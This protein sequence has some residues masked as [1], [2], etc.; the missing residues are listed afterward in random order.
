MATERT[1]PAWPIPFA[2]ALLLWPALWNGYPI[3]FADTGTYL[4]QAIHRYIGWDRPPFYS[5]AI[6]CLHGTVTTWP[7]V[8]AQA[9]ITAWVLR[10][11]IA[12]AWPGLDERWLPV[13]VLPLA[14]GT[15][16]PFLVSELTPDVFTPLLVLGWVT[17]GGAGP[18]TAGGHRWLPIL[19]AF[20]I[21]AQQSSLL[22]TL[23]LLPVLIGLHPKGWRAIMLPPAFAIAA[24]VA[25]NLAGH[26]RAAI[27]PFGQVFLLA[28]VIYDGPGLAVLRR[29]CPEAGWRLCPYRDR[30]PP[31]SDDFLWQADSPIVLAGGHK[32]IA[33]E[34]NA[35]IAAAIL[36]APGQEA[37]AT[38]ANAAEQITRF[39]SG[40]GLESW[41][42]QVTPWIARDFPPREAA[43][44]AAGLQ[45]N[46]RLA[47]PSWLGALHQLI[48]LTGIAVAAILLPLTWRRDRRAAHG[49]LIALLVLPLSAAITGG[50]STPHDRYQSRIA[51]IPAWI[52]ALSLGT[53][54]GA[55]MVRRA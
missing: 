22:L 46:G 44:Y 18:H 51:W 14:L 6:L 55:P 11:S 28:R 4:S 25:V 10:L 48:A 19:I 21:A 47:V 1:H 45:A 29:D 7:V 3:V 27:A 40:D 16:L 12:A 9:L 34:A 2:A 37:R 23:A 43:A 32:T 36:S 49:L 42:N 13:L 35:I 41:P 15:W 17:A 53:A 33:A 52:A 31:T 26:G 54:T 5:L 30:L 50:L 39:A 20:A 24:L 38:L 8:V